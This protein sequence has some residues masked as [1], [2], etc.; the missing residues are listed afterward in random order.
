M[1]GERKVP[2]SVEGTPAA[3]GLDAGGGWVGMRVQ[4]LLDREH[5]A[6]RMVFGRTIFEPGASRHE[7]HRHSGAEEAVLIVRGSGVVVDGD[8]EIAVSPGDVVLHPRNEWH[9]F[10]NTSEV[11]EVEMLWVWSGAASREEAGYEL[12]GP[13][14]GAPGDRAS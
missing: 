12:A 4:F 9:G 6:E 5:G 2:I 14:G 8:R 3:V 1:V 10:R 11:D 13:V 7:T